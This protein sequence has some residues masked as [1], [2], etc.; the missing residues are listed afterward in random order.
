MWGDML[1]DCACCGIGDVWVKGF[2]RKDSP[3]LVYWCRLCSFTMASKS[4]GEQ[5]EILEAIC[6]VGNV[7]LQEIAKQRE[8]TIQDFTV[9]N[10]KLDSLCTVTHPACSQRSPRRSCWQ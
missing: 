3:E 6:F 2:P 5:R 7:I 9:V 1:S 10:E 8:G 4:R